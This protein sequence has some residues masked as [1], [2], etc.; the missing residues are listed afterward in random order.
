M[1][2]NW[3]LA[4]VEPLDDTNYFLWS[5]KVEGILRVKKIWK[6]VI[7]INPPEKPEEDD[8]EY[9]IKFRPWNEWDDNNYAART[10][11]INTMSKTQLLKYSREKNADR[12]WSV[13]K[14]NMAAETEQQKARSLSELTN[15]RMNRDESVDAFINR[16]EVLRNQC[17]Q[18]GR[19]IEEYE[20]VYN[21]RTEAGIRSKC[22][23]IKNSE[24][25]DCLQYTLCVKAGRVAKEYT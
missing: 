6:K 9:A 5:E 15:L 2:N 16:A 7:G 11:M 17:V 24:G 10:V 21:K 1:E 3:N 22:A 25:I 20:N 13:I 12:L 18:L 14:N 8:A 4:S 23:R 19:N